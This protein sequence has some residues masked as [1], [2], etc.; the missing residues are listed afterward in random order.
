MAL[1]QF[2]DTSLY[3]IAAIVIYLY[4]GEKVPS[5]ALSAAGTVAMRKAIWGVAIPTIVITTP[6]PL[7]TTGNCR[8]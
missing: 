5:P 8:C 7:H 6:N 3:L 4:V 2:I 1:L